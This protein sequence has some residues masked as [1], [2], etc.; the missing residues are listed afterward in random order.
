V[1]VAHVHTHAHAH[2]HTKSYTPRLAS[3]KTVQ[4]T[5]PARPLSLQAFTRPDLAWAAPVSLHAS[6][7][8]CQLLVDGVLLIDASEPITTGVLVTKV[9]WCVRQ[10][11]CACVRVCVCV[12]VR[13]WLPVDGVL[14]IDAS[15]PS[16]TGVR[17]TKV[18]AHAH[19]CVCVRVC[20]CVCVCVFVAASCLWMASC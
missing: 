16:T 10:S 4:S 1:H 9:R 8:G 7:M 17:V 2:A 3:D 13:V 12:R 19:V 6:C 5:T 11:A 18:C 14:L 15:E 20:V